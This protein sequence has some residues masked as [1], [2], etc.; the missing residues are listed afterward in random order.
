MVSTIFK[1]F[2][3]NEALLPKAKLNVN[4]LLLLQRMH[5]SLSSC[6]Q[7]WG[8]IKFLHMCASVHASRFCVHK[9][10]RQL[11]RL[12]WVTCK[13]ELLPITTGDQISKLQSSSPIAVSESVTPSALPRY[14]QRTEMAS[15]SQSSRELCSSTRHTR[16]FSSSSSK[17]SSFNSGYSHG[18][19]LD[20]RSSMAASPIGHSSSSISSCSPCPSCSFSTASLRRKP[21]P[22]RGQVKARI[23]RSFLRCVVSLIVSL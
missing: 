5:S 8:H 3:D 16:N 22:R 17:S 19:S 21:L 14:L 4:N 15:Y 20:R 2:A 6:I 12:K 11:E 13:Q 9:V 18:H 7:S 1:A 23:A 10:I